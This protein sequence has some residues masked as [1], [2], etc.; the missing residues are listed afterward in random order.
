MNSD[1]QKDNHQI[2]EYGINIVFFNIVAVVLCKTMDKSM[3][4]YN[5]ARREENTRY[6]RSNEVRTKVS[7]STMN[8]YHTIALHRLLFVVVYMFVVIMMK[9]L[10]L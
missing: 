10:H 3:K 7:I 2:V 4:I 1:S 6:R 8:I 9:I 5:Q